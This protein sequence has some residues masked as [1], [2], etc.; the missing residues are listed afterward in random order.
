MQK[1]IGV[2]I[3]TTGIKACEVTVSGSGQITLK[4]VGFVPLA[5]AQVIDGE[6]KDPDGVSAALIK[7]FKE[8]KFQNRKI[9]TVIGSEPVSLV[10]GA[11]IHKGETRA[12]K[13][14][15]VTAAALDVIPTD[16]Q[17]QFLDFHELGESDELSETGENVTKTDVIILSANKAIVETLTTT[18]ED[19][20][21]IPLRIDHVAMALTRL[22]LPISTGDKMDFIVH[23]GHN[24]LDVVGVLDGHPVYVHSLHDF[25]SGRITDALVDYLQLTPKEADEAKVKNKPETAEV[26]TVWVSAIAKTIKG[27]A[28]DAAQDRNRPIGKVWLSGGGA[29]LHGLVGYLGAIL[30][31]GAVATKLDLSSRLTNPQRLIDAEDKF[32]TDFTL[33]VAAGI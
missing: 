11:R 30:P 18:F 22:V 26:V 12:D 1:A 20:K 16:I 31:H 9:A 4:K 10:R 32:V 33:A 28:E 7:L 8:T 24:N 29:K 6:V 5:D 2:D 19:A 21:L 3:G 17:T 25:A 27:L 15:L 13:M 23:V 14:A